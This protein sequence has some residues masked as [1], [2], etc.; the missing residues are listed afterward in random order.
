MKNAKLLFRRSVLF[1]KYRNRLARALRGEIK[2]GQNCRCNVG[3][4]LSCSEILPC[5]HRCSVHHKRRILSG[6]I[7]G[8]CTRIA[9]VICRNHQH[10]LLTHRCQKFRQALIEVRQ[11]FCVALDIIAVSVEHVVIH[12]IR[13]STVR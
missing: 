10:I 8:R 12:Q 4:A 1:L 2:V 9:A 11:C 13:K 7:R 3:K 5:P 6:M